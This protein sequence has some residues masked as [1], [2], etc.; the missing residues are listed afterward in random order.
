MTTARDFPN[1]E[2]DTTV[3]EFSYTQENKAISYYCCII[4]RETP[5]T[6]TGLTW[7]VLKQI[8]SHTPTYEYW[9]RYA[10][11]EMDFKNFVLEALNTDI[12][13]KY[14]AEK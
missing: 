12:F 10:V 11:A 14:S 5:E 4:R 3:K 6:E 8:G 7:E 13:Y 1:T 2:N 9:D